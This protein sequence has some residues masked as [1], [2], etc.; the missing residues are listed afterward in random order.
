MSR[1]ETD[2]MVSK[3]SGGSLTAAKLD[4][5]ASLGIPIVV[6]A[7]PPRPAADL[8]TVET[9]EQALAVLRRVRSGI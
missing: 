9:A 3:D 6:I 8:T 2:L 4:A 1:A 7:R 5:A